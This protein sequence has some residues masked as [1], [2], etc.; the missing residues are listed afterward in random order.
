MTPALT[1]RSRFCPPQGASIRLS[2][3]IPLSA[4]Y[5]A[6]RAL[7]GLAVKRIS[8]IVLASIVVPMTLCAAEAPLGWPEV[9]S[10]LAK[11]RTQATTCVQVLKSNGDKAAV[12]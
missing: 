11:A 12:A 10:L 4:Y 3:V 8:L 2:L 6:Q 9:I 1:V 5:A 7:E